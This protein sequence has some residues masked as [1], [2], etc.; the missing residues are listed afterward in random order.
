MNN[1]HKDESMRINTESVTEESLLLHG[2][3]PAAACARNMLPSLA[4]A[5]T[6]LTFGGMAWIVTTMTGDSSPYV[7]VPMVTS[8]VTSILGMSGCCMAC[9]ESRRYDCCCVERE[10]HQVVGTC[11][12]LATAAL[13]IWG[14]TKLPQ[15][16]DPNIIWN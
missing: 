16:N 4:I 10:F 1:E 12:C 15:V 11:S 3:T 9:S 7:L 5:G 6:L 2:G 14:C 8:L 13:L